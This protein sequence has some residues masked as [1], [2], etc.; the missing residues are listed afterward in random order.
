MFRNYA[1]KKEN[2]SKG[3]AL[4][5]GMSDAGLSSCDGDSDDMMVINCPHLADIVWSEHLGLEHW[6]RTH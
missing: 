1:G 6:V 3:T 4:V 5:N 2:K